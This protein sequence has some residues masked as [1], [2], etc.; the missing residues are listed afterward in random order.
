MN[1]TTFVPSVS[2]ATALPKETSWSGPLFVPSASPV[3][4][5][6]VPGQ[7]IDAYTN[8]SADALVDFVLNHLDDEERKWLLEDLLTA[9]HRSWQTG[10]PEPLGEVLADWEETVE[11]KLDPLLSHQLDE[12]FEEADRV[13]ESERS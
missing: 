9:V 12:A 8:R 2:S 7:S 6:T 5:E 11:V 4:T 3:K 1:T 13:R 10:S